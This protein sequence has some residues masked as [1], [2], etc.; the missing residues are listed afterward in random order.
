[1]GLDKPV[2]QGGE[3]IGKASEKAS[4]VSLANNVI[5]LS[6]M[7][8]SKVLRGMSTTNHDA[9]CAKYR[10]QLQNRFAWENLMVEGLQDLRRK[11]IAALGVDGRV[12]KEEMYN[13]KEHSYVELLSPD[14]TEEEA[15]CLLLRNITKQGEIIFDLAIW[16]ET[17]ENARPKRRYRIPAAM[18]TRSKSVEYATWD[19]KTQ[20]AVSPWLPLNEIVTTLVQ[21]LE[22]ELDFNPLADSFAANNGRLGFV[23]QDP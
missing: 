7:R 17:S 20:Q 22:A 5:S 9:L 21:S 2:R 16:L 3:I 10:A 19:P 8:K 6:R 11:M 18:R 4:L 13:P 14:G 12:W 1:V 15:A 23:I